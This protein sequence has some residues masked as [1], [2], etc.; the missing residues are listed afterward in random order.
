MNRLANF[1]VGFLAVAPASVFA[2]TAQT[3]YKFVDESGR[4]TYANAPIKGGIKLA[5]EPL[6]IMQSA[7][8]APIAP[9]ASNAPNLQPPPARVVPV[10]K[11][12]SVPSPSYAAVRPVSFTPAATVAPPPALAIVAP[13]AAPSPTTVAV[14]DA[15]ENTLLLAQQ[16]RAEVRQ[17]IVQSEIQA[18]EKSL[19]GAR[20]ALTAE[21]R[22]SGEIR[23]MRASFAVNAATATPQKPLISAETRAE[24]ERHFE[25]VRNLQDEVAMHEGNIAALRDEVVAAR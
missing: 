20:A 1:V 13:P 22:R 24:I 10:A 23:T 6:T 19:G 14:L 17:R 21:Q 16:R 4:V 9:I 15:N 8:N 3:I 25:R 18:E 7:P 5:L 2:E 12:V 11:V